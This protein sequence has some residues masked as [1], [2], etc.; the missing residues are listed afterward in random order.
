ME[1]QF[2][3]MTTTKY[4]RYVLGRPNINDNGTQPNKDTQALGQG[5]H[6]IFCMIVT[7]KF[8]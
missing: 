2:T 4:L 6:C 5:L 8:N 3:L 7:F 1:K